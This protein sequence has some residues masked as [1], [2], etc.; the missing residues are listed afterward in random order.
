M[1][2][3]LMHRVCLVE[4]VVKCIDDEMY[5]HVKKRKERQQHDDHYIKEKRGDASA[6]IINILE[7]R[8]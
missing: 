2:R 1:M 8:W 7:D 5:T 6:K 3:V 4:V